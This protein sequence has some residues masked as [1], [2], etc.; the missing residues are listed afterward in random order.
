VL[1]D[2]KSHLRI[3]SAA[4]IVDRGCGWQGRMSHDGCGYPKK[5]DQPA[6][7]NRKAQL[8]AK[9]T[10]KWDTLAAEGLEAYSLLGLSLGTSRGTHV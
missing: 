4:M 8:F 1:S 10:R 3:G 5:W 6:V 2:N 7:D 9:D